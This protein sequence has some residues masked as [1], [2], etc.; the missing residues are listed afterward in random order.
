MTTYPAFS[1]RRHVA[2]ACTAARAINRL[3]T[4]SAGRPPASRSRGWTMSV[5]A[6]RHVSRL[7]IAGMSL[8][9][10]VALG[11]CASDAPT[12]ATP[13]RDAPLPPP[14]WTLVITPSR[15][16]MYVG[17]SVTL[18]LR[19]TDAGGAQI[20]ANIAATWTTSDAG[21]A[22]A[23]SRGSR[24]TAVTAIRPGIVTITVTLQGRSAS[25]ELTI[26]PLPDAA[27]SLL[28]VESFRMIEFQYPSAPDQ[29]FYAPQ[30]RLR[31]T[32]YKDGAVVTGVT[33]LIPGLGATPPCNT[34]IFVGAHSVVQISNEIDSNLQFA[35][36]GV[37]STGGEASAIVT[38]TDGRGVRTDVV[39]RGPIVAGKL[40][41]TNTSGGVALTCL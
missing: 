38:V 17:E 11:G 29:W 7:I 23:E 14:L 25:R 1:S 31:G 21:V 10:L 26:L 34:V 36:S 30:M 6:A 2:L 5:V 40:P 39:A 15:D 27:G 41:Q 9:G 13:A 35:Q 33:F 19:A 3:T 8:T 16:R 32:G 4:A 22:S 12:A 20:A 37:R 24:E 18:F 28:I